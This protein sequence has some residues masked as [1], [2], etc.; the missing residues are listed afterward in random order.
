MLEMEYKPIVWAN[1]NRMVM[2]TGHK[3][4]DRQTN[5]VGTGNMIANTQHSSYIRPYTETKCWGPDEFPKG[6]LRNYDLAAFRSM[7][8][9][10]RKKVESLTETNKVILYEFYHYNAGGWRGMNYQR[11]D[12]RIT[13]GYVVTDSNGRLLFKVVTG[14]TSKSRK[15][16]DEVAKY[17]SWGG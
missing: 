8:R 3:T 13:H 16:V 10:V 2:E 5:I 9:N 6:H 11:V 1:P 15:V 12:R 17:V 14:P 4:F 7:P